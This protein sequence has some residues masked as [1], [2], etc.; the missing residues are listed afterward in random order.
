MD[1]RPLPAGFGKCPQCAY[2][3]TGS[4]AICSECANKTLER[5]PANPCALCGL[6]LRAD[7]TCGNPLCNWTEADRYFRRLYA[8]SIGPAR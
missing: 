1:T 8:I 6:A 5:L 3:G 7:H 4:V 2:A